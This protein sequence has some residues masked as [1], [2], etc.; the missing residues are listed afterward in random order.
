MLR[1]KGSTK[2][3]GYINMPSTYLTMSAYGR[4]GGLPICL[5]IVKQI[6]GTKLI[7]ISLNQLL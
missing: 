3:R 6:Q 7:V 5:A 2:F 1:K 4:L